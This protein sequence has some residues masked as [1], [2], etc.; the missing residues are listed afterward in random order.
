MKKRKVLFISTKALTQN[1]FFKEFIKK[2]PFDLTLG[3]SDVEKLEFSNKKIKFNFIDNFWKLLNPFSILQIILKNRK[4]ILNNKF[5][6]III[7]N[8]LASFYIRLSLLFSDQKIIYFVHGYRFHNS[9]IN[10]KYFIF[11][12]LEKL[13]SYQ[14]NFFI[15][16]NRDDFIVTKKK[17]KILSKNI[18]FLPSVGIDL[19]KLKKIKNKSKNKKFTIGVIAAY[20]DNKGYNELIDASEFLHLNNNDV[21]IECFGYDNFEKYKKIVKTK[22]L[23]NIKFNKFKN[24][25]HKNIKSFDLLCHMSKREGMPVSIIESISLGVPVIAYKIRGNKD[26]IKNYFNGYLIDPYNLSQFKKILSRIV[27]G[28][29]D[30][31]KTKKNCNT[32]NL[33]KH[34]QKNINKKLIRFIS[35]VS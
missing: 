30:I 29:I 8:P 7:N 21:K 22:N 11:Y 26:I 25:I 17:F 24:N 4:K 23:K 15:N 3:C 34:D 32:Y 19:K 27:S 31:S 1:I 33:K 9:E 16:I 28:K 14:T 13:L 6:I 10:L 12:Y 2:N 5:E 35:N 18:L 20:R